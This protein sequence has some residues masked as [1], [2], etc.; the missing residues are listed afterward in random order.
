MSGQL[1]PLI[2]AVLIQAVG[3]A[4]FQVDNPTMVFHQNFQSSVAS[5]AQLVSAKNLKAAGP[6]TT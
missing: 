6:P 1:G 5:D 3:S 4:G 2:V